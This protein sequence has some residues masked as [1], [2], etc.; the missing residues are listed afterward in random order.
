MPT[1]NPHY[2][3]GERPVI[4][5]PLIITQLYLLRH[6]EF[7]VDVLILQGPSA[8]KSATRTGPVSWNFGLIDRSGLIYERDVSH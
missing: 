7:N 2:I 1:Y 6:L 5:E 4:L 8:P 3:D